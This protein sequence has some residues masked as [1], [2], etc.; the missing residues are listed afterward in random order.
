MLV[1]VC[2]LRRTRSESQS[3]RAVGKGADGSEQQRFAKRFVKPS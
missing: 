2:K 3:D 1:G